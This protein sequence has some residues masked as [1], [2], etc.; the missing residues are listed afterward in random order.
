MPLLVVS[1][2]HAIAGMAH[3]VLRMSG[4]ARRGFGATLTVVAY[5]SGPLLFAGLPICGPL[6][7]AGAV[8]LIVIGLAE[9]HRCSRWKAVLAVF[10]LLFL[11]CAVAGV[12]GFMALISLNHGMWL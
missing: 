1:V 11:G 2:L 3:L 5:A 4:A 12:M 7:V 10:P 9:A 6:C 8:A